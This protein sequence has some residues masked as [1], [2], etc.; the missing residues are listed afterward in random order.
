MTLDRDAAFYVAG[1]RGMVG[2]AVVRALK[3]RGHGRV[4]T[5]TRAEADL[6]DFAAV[7]ALFVRE[8]PA[9]VALAAAKVGGILANDRF[10]GDFI[11]E[12]LQI[13]TNVIDAAPTRRAP[14]RLPRLEL[15]LS[16]RGGEPDPRGSA[17][18]RTARGDEPA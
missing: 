8:K 6:T 1:H 11:R 18:D 4:V 16:A 13:Q 10:G 14:L 5:A 2:G 17:A 9:Y 7:E 15:H 12:N 3:A